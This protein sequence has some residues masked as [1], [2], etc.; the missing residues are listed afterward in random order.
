MVY[1][2]S[3][4]LILKTHTVFQMDHSFQN[5]NKFIQASLIAQ[6]VKRIHLQCR[7]PRFDSWVG[8]IRWRKDRPPT[9][10]FLGFP[11]GS[12]DKESAHNV[13]DLGL[14]PGLGR[15]PGEGKGYRLWYSGLENSMDSIVGS[16][17]QTWLSDFP[18]YACFLHLTQCLSLYSCVYLLLRG[19]TPPSCSIKFLLLK[20]PVVSHQSQVKSC[21][22]SYSIL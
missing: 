5:L 1:H 4:G 8:K 14:I 19:S 18:V 16:Q 9:P 3:G 11:C 7:R 22:T 17:S 6:L 15:S 2:L 21:L 10:V 13:G 20:L 12:A